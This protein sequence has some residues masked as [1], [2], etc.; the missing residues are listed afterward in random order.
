MKITLIGIILLWFSS[1]LSIQAVEVNQAFRIGIYDL[2]PNHIQL[3]TNRN[4]VGTFA[5]LLNCIVDALDIEY[6]VLQ[7]PMLR[8]QKMLATGAIDAA[9]LMNA[10]QKRSLMFTQSTPLFVSEQLIISLKDNPVN[11]D[12]IYKHSFVV[13]RGSSYE[14]YLKS[15]LHK[16]VMEVV[17]A[18]LTQE[19]ILSK[20]ADA[21]IL[22]KSAWNNIVKPTILESDRSKFHLAKLDAM[23]KEVVF[24]FN[25]DSD[26]KYGF[27]TLINN[28]IPQCVNNVEVTS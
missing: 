4:V 22:S 3:D 11:Q 17:S 19:V 13:V 7:L 10:T 5:P 25:K 9:F 2:A 23:S 21:T 28:V 16:N 24:Y 1:C 6:L 12:S 20:R 15:I 26:A 27:S 14:G 8:L 18:K